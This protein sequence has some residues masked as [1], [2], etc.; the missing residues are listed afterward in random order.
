MLRIGY[1]AQR[2]QDELMNK[3]LPQPVINL[4][5]I[6]EKKKVE[7]RFTQVEVAKELGW[8]QGA[9]SHYLNN[10]TELRAQ[11]IIKLANFLDVDPRE[12]DPEIEENLPSIVKQTVSYNASDMTKRINESLLTRSEEA[13]IIVKMSA[14]DYPYLF[15]AAGGVMK[16]WDCYARLVSVS[17]MKKP[18]AFAARLKGKKYLKFYPPNDLPDSSKIHT[19]WSVVAFYYS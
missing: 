2:I 10:I 1:T 14:D 12:I 8:S 5:R 7:M 13:S 16:D 4:R 3:D 15:A 19:M 11:A 6:W 18:R 9:I 17:Q